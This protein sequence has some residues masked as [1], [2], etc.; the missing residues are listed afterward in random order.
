MF[1]PKKIW[2]LFGLIMLFS[3]PVFANVSIIIT[4]SSNE[5]NVG[6]NVNY[7]LVITNDG[8]EIEPDLQIQYIFSPSMVIGEIIGGTCADGT[9]TL[10]EL[11]VGDTVTITIPVTVPNTVHDVGSEKIT[12]TASNDG[13]S[14]P[15]DAV[16][17]LKPKLSL[18]V[19]PSPT[20]VVIGQQIIYEMP[21]TN[22]GTGAA[23]G[24][25]VEYG[26]PDVADI[27]IGEI[28]GAG[29]NCD[30]TTCELIGNLDAGITKTITFPITAPN[31][32][33]QLKF[34]TTV[35][36]GSPAQSSAV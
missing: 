27:V 4:T 6:G 31:I 1:N 15:N 25:R 11:G 8:L 23:T 13:N 10:D 2:V 7:D 17:I 29:W 9:C 3:H 22:D 34:I 5:V 18:S 28:V 14:F 19:I 32:V 20:K 33:G 24:V 30:A 12:L 26:F 16:A 21:I 35:T 36:G